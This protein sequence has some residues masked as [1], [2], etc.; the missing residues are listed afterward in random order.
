MSDGGGDDSDGAGSLDERSA[1]GQVEWTKVKREARSAQVSL[2]NPFDP[3]HFIVGHNEPARR[4]PNR[5]QGGV[6]SPNLDGQVGSH[7]VDL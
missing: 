3:A 5:Q 6:Y 4:E 1:G 7:L 2:E